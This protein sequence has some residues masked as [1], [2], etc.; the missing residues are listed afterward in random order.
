[1]AGFDLATTN[2][3]YSLVNADGRFAINAAT[4]VVTVA[5]G[6]LLDYEAARSHP[7]VARAADQSG[8]V[9]D[10]VFTIDVG[11]VNEAPVDATLAGGAV[12]ENSPNGGAG[13]DYL[14]GQDGNDILRGGANT[15]FL[16]GGAGNDTYVFN[17]GDGAEALW[18]HRPLNRNRRA[19]ARS[20][21]RGSGCRHARGAVA[22]LACL[23]GS[24]NRQSYSEN[25]HSESSHA[26]CA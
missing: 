4:G 14:F 21:V 19:M 17:R 26:I 6:A 11:N 3:S 8:H 18:S 12:A 10:K 23:N 25:A 2:L 13:N 24:R 5:N 16:F 7:I 20:R 9:F 22:S 15:D 1:V